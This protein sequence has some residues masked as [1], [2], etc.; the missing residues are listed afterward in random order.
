VFLKHYAP[1]IK[2]LEQVKMDA[3]QRI[4]DAQAQEWTAKHKQD[5]VTNIAGGRR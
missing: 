2:E 1:M 3:R 4:V 5:K